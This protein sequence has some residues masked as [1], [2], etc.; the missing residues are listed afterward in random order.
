MSMAT[1]EMPAGVGCKGEKMPQKKNLK[2]QAP[3]AHNCVALNDTSH[4]H[5]P[6]CSPHVSMPHDT[7]SLLCPPPCSSTAP[8]NPTIQTCSDTPLHQVSSQH[9]N[10]SLQFQSPASPYLPYQ[11]PFSPCP[12]YDHPCYYNST[13]T[14]FT[15]STCTVTLCTLFL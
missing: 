11:A 15:L 2:K 12:F 6:P 1:H 9:M 8:S 5:T 10:S 3:S 14:I 13:G 4:S 7:R